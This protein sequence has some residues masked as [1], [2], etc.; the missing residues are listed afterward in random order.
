MSMHGG[1]GANK[2]PTDNNGVVHG[3][4]DALGAHDLSA[5]SAAETLGLAVKALKLQAGVVAGLA[6]LSG[7]APDFLAAVAALEKQIDA[8]AP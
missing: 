6:A 4:A 7:R 5:P 1:I 3:G 8:L 2:S